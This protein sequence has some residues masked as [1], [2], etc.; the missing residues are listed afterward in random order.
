MS[1]PE[2]GIWFTENACNTKRFTQFQSDVSENFTV[3][4]IQEDC[5]S[6]TQ[7]WIGSKLNV[8]IMEKYERTVSTCFSNDGPE[9]APDLVKNSLQHLLAICSIDRKKHGLNSCCSCFISSLIVNRTICLKR[10]KN[11]ISISQ[12]RIRLL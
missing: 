4:L 10:N 8:V 12:L 5:R 2:V 6:V 9:N 11:W 7:E 3:K 1:K